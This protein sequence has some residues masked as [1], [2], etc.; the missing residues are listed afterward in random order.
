LFRIVN[1]TVESVFFLD[2]T[3]VYSTG[4]TVVSKLSVVSNLQLI[5]VKLR[6]TVFILHF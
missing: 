2:F 4:S 3:V 5:A 1:L 6:F